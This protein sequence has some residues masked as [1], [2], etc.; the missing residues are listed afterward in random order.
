M[1]LPSTQRLDPTPLVLTPYLHGLLQLL[2]IVM[3][4]QHHE[5]QN[6]PRQVSRELRLQ[7]SHQVLKRV[8]SRSYLHQHLPHVTQDGEETWHKGM[9]SPWVQES[10]SLSLLVLV[11]L[12]ENKEG[13]TKQEDCS[14]WR[15]E[16]GRKGALPKGIISILGKLAS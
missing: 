16:K 2:G 3:G 15:Q 13:W 1:G 5:P 8:E 10:G 7:V 9:D 12:E 6:Q 11:Y 14:P 4:R